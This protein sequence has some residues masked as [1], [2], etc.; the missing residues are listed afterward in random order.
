MMTRAGI[1][2]SIAWLR[3]LKYLLK[4]LKARWP[5]AF[6]LTVRIITNGRLT[7]EVPEVLY[8]KQFDLYLGVLSARSIGIICQLPDTV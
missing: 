4:W 6:A 3:V 1:N 2:T 7:A 8:V 5:V